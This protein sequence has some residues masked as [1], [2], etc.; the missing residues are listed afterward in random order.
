M[1]TITTWDRVVKR[2]LVISDQTDI[3]DTISRIGEAEGFEVYVAG[4][5]AT[6]KIAYGAFAPNVIVLD[7][8]MAG[9]NA[10]ELLKY[11]A[12]QGCKATIM[13]LHAK[14]NLV[15]PMVEQ[16]PVLRQLDIAGGL[17]E[18]L[19]ASELRRRLTSI[20]QKH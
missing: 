9:V 16:S 15:R 11:L 4:N 2:L 1:A 6:F 20:K 19:R 10:W 8:L 18:P 13:F 5:G 12:A 7:M 17:E 3:A 14:D